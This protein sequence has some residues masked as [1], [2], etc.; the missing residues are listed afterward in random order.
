MDKSNKKTKAKI[1]TFV[2]TQTNPKSHLNL[3]KK[4]PTKK[5]IKENTYEY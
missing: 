3:P 4:N 5:S 2:Q 1:P